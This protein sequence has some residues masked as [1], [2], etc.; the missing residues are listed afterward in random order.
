VYGSA[1]EYA[2]RILGGFSA[3]AAHNK[4][5]SLACFIGVIVTTL[6]VSVFVAFGEGRTYGKIV[7]V[8]LSLIATAL[9]T[10][11]QFR[12]PH[13]LWGIY[14]SAQRYIE[15][16]LVRYHFGLEE[17]SDGDKDK[18]LARNVAA[19][20]LAAH[21]QWVPLIPSPEGLDKMKAHSGRD[22]AL[23]VR[24]KDKNDGSSD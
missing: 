15:D 3:K 23:A 13:Q 21:E 2:Q 5:E 24:D 14:R 11:L 19:I 6:A 18:L 4:K 9:S 7:P 1:A 12:K 17:Y 20:A 8:C 16:H 22:I 10:W